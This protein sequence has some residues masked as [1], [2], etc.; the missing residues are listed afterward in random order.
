MKRTHLLKVMLIMAFVPFLLSCHDSEDEVQNSYFPELKG[1]FTVEIGPDLWE[2]EG[3][4][5]GD[6]IGVPEESK[7]IPFT[8]YRHIYFKRSD[9]PETNLSEGDV[10]DIKILKYSIFM[11]TISNGRMVV[12]PIE[13]T[14]VAPCQ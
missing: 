10:I 11:G 5:G 4:A 6:I 14:E 9:L 3:I 7:E 8:L 2:D 1:C 12:Y 13:A